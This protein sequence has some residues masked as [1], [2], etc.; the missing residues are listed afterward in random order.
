M[1]WKFLWAKQFKTTRI[2]FLLELLLERI[3]ASSTVL[4]SAKVQILTQ[5]SHSSSSM[6]CLYVG[7][8][9][10]VHCTKF[11]LAGLVP[12]Y[13]STALIRLIVAC[14]YARADSQS[15]R[16]YD[17]RTH[18]TYFFGKSEFFLEIKNKTNDVTLTADRRTRNFFYYV[19]LPER[20]TEWLTDHFSEKKNITSQLPSDLRTIFQKIKN[21]PT[22][23]VPRT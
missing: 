12:T 7:C 4:S 22:Y 16:G 5:L 3:L 14:T 18:S 8:A 13:P 19:I 6:V 11:S 10:E 9:Q 21:I 17:T 15:D 2:F 1:L 23:G 20:P